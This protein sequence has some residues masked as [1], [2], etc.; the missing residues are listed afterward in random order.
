MVGGDA[1]HQLVQLEAQ[2]VCRLSV[3]VKI[4]TYFG[5][6]HRLYLNILTHVRMTFF[7]IYWTE[8]VT[9]V[10]FICVEFIQ[11]VPY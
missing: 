7:F 9:V 4:L 2:L 1:N 3:L 8:R 10:L 5:S 11:K 6:S